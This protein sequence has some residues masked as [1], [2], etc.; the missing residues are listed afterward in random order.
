MDGGARIV[1]SSGRHLYADPDTRGILRQAVL[2]ELP[3]RSQCSQWLEGSM[4]W[5]SV[6]PW[7]RSGVEERSHS[8]SVEWS[9]VVSGRSMELHGAPK[10]MSP[11]LIRHSYIPFWKAVSFCQIV[12]Q[13]QIL[14]LSPSKFLPL[15]PCQL[16]LQFRTG[17]PMHVLPLS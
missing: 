12:S 13:S 14:P 11:N 1:E 9:G 16:N 7:L 15:R 10:G 2:P 17:Y 4:E 3:A 6:T 8:N 5:S